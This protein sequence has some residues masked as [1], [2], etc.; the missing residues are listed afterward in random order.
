MDMW[1]VWL[2]LA[3][4][5]VVAEV[6]TTGF[7]L[8]WFGVGA[9]VAAMLALVGI[10]SLPVQIAA[11]LL[12]STALT[13]ASRTIFERVFVRNRPAGMKMGMESLPGQVGTVVKPSVGALAEGAVKVYGSTW[14]ALP[15]DGEEPLEEGERVCVDRVEGAKIYV[16]R[17][18]QEG[19][20]WRS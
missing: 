20:S 16:R 13:V 11:F 2:A 9:L 10:E 5:F 4:V 19:P 3:L 7:V 18:R 1:I 6:L 15:V 12:V 17:V 8:F 14:T